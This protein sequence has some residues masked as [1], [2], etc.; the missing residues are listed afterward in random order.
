MSKNYA[1]ILFAGYLEGLLGKHWYIEYII[2]NRDEFKTTMV[3]RSL[4][5]YLQLEDITLIKI[6][7]IYKQ[8]MEGKVNLSNPKLDIT[9]MELKTNKGDIIEENDSSF[10][11]QT[12]INNLI[13]E[14]IKKIGKIEAE[15]FNLNIDEFISSDIIKAHIEANWKLFL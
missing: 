9:K 12:V 2:K 4:S 3:L 7:D 11:V 1:N 10:V 5:L 14:H 13:N 8:A 6:E 15:N